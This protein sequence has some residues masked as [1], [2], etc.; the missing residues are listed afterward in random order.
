MHQDVYKAYHRATH[1]VAKTR[2]VVM[3]YDGALRNLKQAKDAMVAGDVPTRFQK[4]VR[5][6]DIIMGLQSSLDFDA[7]GDVAKILYDFYSSLDARILS[8]LNSNNTELVD[9]LMQEIRDMR[10][11][12]ESIDKQQGDVPAEPAANSAAATLNPVTV[13][14]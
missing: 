10:D 3:L 9:Q 5:A 2:Q 4:L 12:W 8:T 13:S 6:G 14:A 11:V 1:T 7:G